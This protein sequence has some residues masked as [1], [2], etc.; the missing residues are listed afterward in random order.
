MLLLNAW[1]YIQIINNLCNKIHII[2][3][4]TF[5]ENGKQNFYLEN[6]W[7]F[8]GMDNYIKDLLDYQKLYLSNEVDHVKQN[9]HWVLGL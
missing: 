4:I 7:Y 9:R 1:T 2:N 8:C 6:S 3:C 5:W